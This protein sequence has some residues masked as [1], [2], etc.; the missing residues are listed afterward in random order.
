[1]RPPHRAPIQTA[2]GVRPWHL[3][4]LTYASTSTS[5]L[6]GSSK[7][8]EHQVFGPEK[9]GFRIPLP[10][11]VSSGPIRASIRGVT[12]AADGP[13]PRR[14]AGA[15]ACASADAQGCCTISA[16]CPMVF[17]ARARSAGRR[18]P[19]GGSSVVDSPESCHRAPAGRPGCR[20]LAV[21]AGSQTGRAAPVGRRS[22]APSTQWALLWKGTLDRAQRPMFPLID[23]PRPGARAGERTRPRGAAGAPAGRWSRA[24]SPTRRG[25]RQGFRGAGAEDGA[26]L[27]VV[28]T[29]KG[30]RRERARSS[31][32][33]RS[34][35][36][37]TPSTAGCLAGGAAAIE[38]SRKRAS[39]ELYLAA[40]D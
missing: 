3:A 37:S 36:A 19:A 7:G 29:K 5:P 20:A 12:P 16:A 9:S 13:D 34:T 15:R 2:Q 28:E 23:A 21:A 31:N 25:L 24:C 6:G 33:R 11:Q 4:S 40:G 8:R 39:G 35:P 38:R 10:P 30:G 22:G 14:G 1:M 27:R 17:V 18:P 26:V 32:I